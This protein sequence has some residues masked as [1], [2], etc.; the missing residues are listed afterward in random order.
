MGY[1]NVVHLVGGVAAWKA[2][3]GSLV[4]PKARACEALTLF[5]TRRNGHMWCSSQLVR[6]LASLMAPAIAFSGVALSPRVVCAGDIS[7][8][9]AWAPA[10]PPKAT[11]GN[12]YMTI[13]NTSSE[14]DHLLAAATEISGTAEI[15]GIRMAGGAAP[16]KQLL[17]LDVPAH[18]SVE[19]KPGT[20]HV[21]LR[22]LKRPLVSGETFQGTL[23]F[24]RSGVIAVRYEVKPLDRTTAPE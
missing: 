20:Y 5:P 11:I 17:N 24:A 9:R 7:V 21:L 3:G 10:T 8:E 18:G 23:T 12:G 13:V 22:N 15:D 1:S 2:A 19:F 6:R 14:P 4:A 16:M